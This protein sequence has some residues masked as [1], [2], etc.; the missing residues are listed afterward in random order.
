MRTR[1][2]LTVINSQLKN[3]VCYR[4][5]NPT[6]CYYLFTKH[7]QVS[8]LNSEDDVEWAGVLQ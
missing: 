5:S 3:H 6:E 2:W 7:E 4:S 8:E 1:K